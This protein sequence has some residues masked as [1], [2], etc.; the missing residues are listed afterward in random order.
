VE[1]GVPCGNQDG[2]Q[3]YQGA[4]IESV[5]LNPFNS[6]QT[7]WEPCWNCSDMQLS[8][9]WCRGQDPFT[10]RMTSVDLD[11]CSPPIPLAARICLNTTS[12]PPCVPINS[13][14]YIDALAQSL[15][16]EYDMIGKAEELRASIPRMCGPNHLVL[17]PPSDSA[18][19]TTLEQQAND[20]W[21][22]TVG[23]CVPGMF[24]CVVFFLYWFCNCCCGCRKKGC[25]KEETEKEDYYTASNNFMHYIVFLGFG[26]ILAG[27]AALGLF[28]NGEVGRA[29]ID[30]ELGIVNVMYGVLDTATTTALNLDVPL[31]AIVNTPVNE[32]ID[33]LD[34]VSYTLQY[35]MDDTITA[36]EDLSDYFRDISTINIPSRTVTSTTS[37]SSRTGTAAGTSTTC[38]M[39]SDSADGV[40]DAV[41]L[42]DQVRTAMQ[43]L[44]GFVLMFREALL[45]ISENVQPGGAINDLQVSA[46]ELI[47]TLEAAEPSLADYMDTVTGFENGRYLFTC[48][49]FGG[50]FYGFVS[51]IFAGITQDGTHFYHHYGVFLFVLPT[52]WFLFGLH[53]PFALVFGDS[54]EL[55]DSGERDP[56]NI[57]YWDPQVA[58]LFSTCLANGSLTTA[59]NLS[60]EWSLSSIELPELDPDTLF[61]DMTAMTD[62]ISSVD[63]LDLSDFGLA[64]VEADVVS[65]F[66]A[67]VRLYRSNTIQC[68]YTAFGSCPIESAL[69]Y[70]IQEI[71]NCKASALISLDLVVFVNNAIDDLKRINRDLNASIY[72]RD[73]TN[74]G[75]EYLIEESNDSLHLILSNLEDLLVSIQAIL[76]LMYCGELG[77]IYYTFKYSFCSRLTTAISFL[78]LSLWMCGILTV[79]QFPFAVRLGNGCKKHNKVHNYG[80]KDEEAAST[81]GGHH[82]GHHSQHGRHVKVVKKG[83]YDSDDEND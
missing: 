1:D 20:Y 60:G 78:A 68:T 72:S 63:A 73:D 9:T 56:V 11:Y 28:M 67:C 39:C 24:F 42:M 18:N 32:S 58:L 27:F 10:G 25:C 26:M 50:F 77:E 45:M 4:C 59:F 23:T 30:P 2:Q 54:C 34:I 36:L 38:S 80:P 53:V 12:D 76:G 41:A 21:P 29:I 15:Y 6:W 62:L 70:D 79:I 31:D 35:G 14:D 74:P 5:D 13:N 16:T 40:D 8:S 37:G 7:S 17:H 64:T 83:R 82:H 51:A 81:H 71:L 33:A 75:I 69:D 57:L 61:G 46:S 47:V 3:C 44:N 43:E 49:M 55:L 65:S 19:F 22:C 66:T 48:F 52:V